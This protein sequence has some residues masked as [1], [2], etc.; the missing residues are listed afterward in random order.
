[1]SGLTEGLWRVSGE[2]DLSHGC[3][4]FPVDAPVC[5]QGAAALPCF[6]L[7]DC[8]LIPLLA[9]PFQASRLRAEFISDKKSARYIFFKLGKEEDEA[10]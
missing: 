8:H 6:F 5:E 1:M 9:L 7:F 10:D 3:I 2:L 4:I